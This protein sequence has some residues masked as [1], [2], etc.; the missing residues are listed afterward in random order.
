[1]P[2]RSTPKTKYYAPSKIVKC[3]VC[4]QEYYSGYKTKHETSQ[5]HM[6]CLEALQKYISNIKQFLSSEN[7]NPATIKV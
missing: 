1:M 6:W 3:D 7:S 5:R 4:G 2:I